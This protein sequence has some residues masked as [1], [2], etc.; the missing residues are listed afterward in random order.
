MA[1]LFNSFKWTA[2]V[3]CKYDRR[4]APLAISHN[5]GHV[6]MDEGDSQVSLPNASI[7]MR[8]QPRPI[9]LYGEGRDGTTSRPRGARGD[10]NI[11]EAT[12]DVPIRSRELAF[13]TWTR[14]LAWA[15]CGFS[16]QLEFLRA[17]R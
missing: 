13:S 3:V 8:S 7:S 6:L 17:V 5:W 2:F 16:E 4:C 9:R 1:D 15:M 10:F 11:R 14:G 12:F